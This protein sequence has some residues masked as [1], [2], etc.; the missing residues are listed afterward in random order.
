MTD[1]SFTATL[2]VA[3]ISVTY[4]NGHRAIHDVSFSL[5]GGTTCA[6]VGAPLIRVPAAAPNSP[7]GH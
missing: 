6:L 1:A 5:K 4:P 3:D 7:P 2:E